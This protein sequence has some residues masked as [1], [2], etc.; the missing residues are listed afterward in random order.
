M[1]ILNF[2]VGALGRAG[3][4]G[5]FLMIVLSLISVLGQWTHIRDNLLLEEPSRDVGGWG[6]AAAPGWTA[7]V[8]LSSHPKGKIWEVG[9]VAME[10]CSLVSHYSKLPSQR[11]SL[12]THLSHF[13]ILE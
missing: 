11:K 12:K 3:G 13:I 9:S 7:V 5:T 6:L 1:E 10:R 4:E 2:T 8:Y